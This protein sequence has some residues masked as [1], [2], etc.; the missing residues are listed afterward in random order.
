M[1][2]GRVAVLGFELGLAFLRFALDNRSYW[3]R[4]FVLVGWLLLIPPITPASE[5]IYAGS[6]GRPAQVGVAA[7]LFQWT[8][9]ARYQS[10]AECDRMRSQVRIRSLRLNPE[11]ATA[12]AYS[13]ARCLEDDDARLRPDKGPADW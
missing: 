1:T 4:I 2:P 3:F 8:V 6:N 7:P 5:G 11:N 13:F 10:A 9:Y 12:V